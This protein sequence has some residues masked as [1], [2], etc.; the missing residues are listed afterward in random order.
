MKVV[1]AGGSGLLGRALTARLVGLGHDV[2]LLTRDAAARRQPGERIRYAEW[3]PD[4]DVGAWALE[5]EGAN[6]IVNLTGADIGQRRW[7]ASR[8]E[9]LRSSRV[10]PTRS[11]VAA[12]RRASLKPSIFIQGSAVGFYGA[13]D[14]DR[15]LDESFPPGDDFLSDLAVVWEAE[16]HPVSALDCRLVIMRSGIVLTGEGGV[17]GRL[18]LPFQFLVGGPVAPGRQYVSWVHRD[19]WVRM[20]LWAMTTPAATGVFNN[21]SP[22]PVTNAEFSRALGRALHRPSWLTVPKFALRI[23]FGELASVALINGLR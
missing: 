15:E 6:A 11:L 4:G 23:L 5:I 7:T 22:I 19:D 8:K 1:V 2:V 3:M 14:N 12:V 13:S 20:V 18:R 10:L 17:V 16:A 21:T 9:E